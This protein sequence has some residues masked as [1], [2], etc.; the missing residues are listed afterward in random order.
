MT[1][2]M[3]GKVHPPPTSTIVTG[4]RCDEAFMT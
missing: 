2:T 4:L 1:R 3:K